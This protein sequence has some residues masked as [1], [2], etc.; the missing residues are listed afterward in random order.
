MIGMLVSSCE[1]NIEDV[2]RL[3]NFEELPLQTIYESK[4]TYTDSGRVHLIIEAGKI[5]RF[6]AGEEPYDEFN[7]GIRV[8]SFN[9][10]GEL[11]SEITA[12]R[13]TNF[14]KRDFMVAKDSVVLKDKEGK[15]LNTELLNWDNTTN[16]IYTDKFVKITTPSEILYGDG[17]EAE[18]DFSRYE[19][20]NIKGRIKID[21]SAD[22]TL[23]TE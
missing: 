4:I 2:N 8:L 6:P 11:E 3:T 19:I 5:D 10:K 20:K 23:Q 1:N 16:K 14:P 17:L 13:A 21:E 9:K 22:S 7:N 12:D 15:M 18:Q